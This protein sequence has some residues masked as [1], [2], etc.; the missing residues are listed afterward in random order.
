M[1]KSNNIKDKL[2]KKLKIIKHADIFQKPLQLN[3]N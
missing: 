3:V 2:F 1:N